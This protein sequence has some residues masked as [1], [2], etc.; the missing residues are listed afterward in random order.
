MLVTSLAGRPEENQPER[1]SAPG[2]S[3]T[4]GVARRGTG[5]ESERG[6]RAERRIGSRAELEG[7][8]EKTKGFY[9]Q[10]LLNE[11]QI[12]GPRIN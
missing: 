8:N 6:A 12:K 9:G 5:R 3:E 4:E 1:K 7:E 10:S 2:G 11:L